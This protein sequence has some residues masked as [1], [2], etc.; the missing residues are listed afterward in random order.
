MYV[1]IYSIYI[2]IY[3]YIYRGYE[4]AEGSRAGRRG[5]GREEGRKE[6]RNS[7]REGKSE[8]GAGGRGGRNSDSRDA[9]TPPR[10]CGVRNFLAIY[11]RRRGRQGRESKGM[12]ST[13]RGERSSERKRERERKIKEGGEREREREGER[14]EGRSRMDDGIVTR[15]WMGASMKPMVCKTSRE[16][17]CGRGQKGGGEST[18]EIARAGSASAEGEE[19]KNARE[20]EG[21]EQGSRECVVINEFRAGESAA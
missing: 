13:R 20:G 5:A 9:R 4:S 6:G 11:R 2:Y 1:H 18:L 19:R 14:P 16:S 3:I 10:V 8:K 17:A 21:R 7:G 15:L 12:R